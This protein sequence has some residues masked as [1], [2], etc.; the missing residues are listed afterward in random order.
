MVQRNLSHPSV[1]KSELSGII[2]RKWL[3]IPKPAIICPTFKTESLQC[4]FVNGI[5]EWHLIS[6]AWNLV[7]SLVASRLSRD[8]LCSRRGYLHPSSVGKG[9]AI[10]YT[11]L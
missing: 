11:Q 1:A 2:W 10:H 9:G 4:L 3:Q 7:S 8:G 5:T 6:E